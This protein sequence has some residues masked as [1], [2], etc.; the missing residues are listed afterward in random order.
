MKELENLVMASPICTLRATNSAVELV[1]PPKTATLVA[2]RYQSH[3]S[4]CL[5]TCLMIN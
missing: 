1:A 4:L 2:H 5:W 3:I